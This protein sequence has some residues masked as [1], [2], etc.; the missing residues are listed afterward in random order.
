MDIVAGSGNDEWYTPDYAVQPILKY[1]KPFK[2]IWCPF[3]LYDSEYV[4]Q[5]RAEGHE[6][7]ATHI[8]NG[9]D[10]FD[11][12]I[13]CDAIVSNPPYSKKTE[14]LDKLF[15]LGKPFAML[16]SVAGIFESQKRFDLF[17]TN[18]FEVMYFNRRVSFIK[19]SAGNIGANPPFSSGYICHDILPQQI[20]FETIKKK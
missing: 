1:L 19:D 6:V 9:E 12:S 11:L 3:D 17:R 14:V 15:K 18:R 5:L 7:I 8:W 4:K 16:I 2:K 13:E 10:F 20:V